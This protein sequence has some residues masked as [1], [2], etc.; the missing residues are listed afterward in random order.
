MGKEHVQS[1]PPMMSDQ[2]VCTYFPAVFGIISGK[3]PFSIPRWN[4]SLYGLLTETDVTV[5]QSVTLGSQDT[6]EELVDADSDSD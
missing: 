4:W 2:E 1:G 6:P 3:Q 5:S